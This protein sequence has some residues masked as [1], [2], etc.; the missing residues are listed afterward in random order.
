MLGLLEDSLSDMQGKLFES[1]SDR[2]YDSQS[3]I[4]AFMTSDIAKRLDSEFNHLQWAGKEYILEEMQKE[5][6]SEL[7]T[8]GEIYDK[9]TLYW[10]GYLY[11]GWHYYTGEDS[12]QIYKQA[13][14]KTLR[15]LFLPYHAMSIEMAIDRLKETYK[16]KHK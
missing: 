6:G 5:L 13:D 4:K 15:K 8:G 16:D 14:A 1:S 7:K 12:K 10:I 9:E 2:G 3:F 11:R